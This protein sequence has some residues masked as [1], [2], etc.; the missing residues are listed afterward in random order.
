MCF[1]T[2]CDKTPCPILIRH[3]KVIIERR[4]MKIMYFNA[5]EWEVHV[6][7]SFSRN[8]VVDKPATCHNRC[9]NLNS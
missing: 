6:T 3:Y 4:T 8:R 5:G 1:C 9:V 2:E 7:I